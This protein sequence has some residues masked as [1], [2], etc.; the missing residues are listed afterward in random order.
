M[1][2]L[3]NHYYGNKEPNNNWLIAVIFIT[4]IILLSN[5]VF[6]QETT[7]RDYCTEGYLNGQYFNLEDPF[8]LEY[9]GNYNL[10]PKVGLWYECG[11]DVADSL[12]IVG[13]SIEILELLIKEFVKESRIK[14]EYW[15]SIK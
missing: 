13:D 9:V 3:T 1:D 6:S 7:N 14:C 12:Y 10:V 11:E 15:K 4:L 2:Y 8:R 5:V